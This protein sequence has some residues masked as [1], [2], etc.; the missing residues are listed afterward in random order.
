MEQPTIRVVYGLTLETGKR[1]RAG[2]E[3]AAQAAGVEILPICR[4]RKEG[5]QTYLTEQ[6]GKTTYI[7]EEG[8]Q[9]SSPYTEDDIIKLAEIGRPHIIFLLDRKHYGT[10]YIKALYLSGIL[11]AVFTQDATG[12][13][14]ARLLLFGR[15]NEE[16]RAYYGIQ[17]H[18]DAQKELEE[19]NTEYL[20]TCLAYIEDSSIHSEMDSRYRFAATRLGQEE[21]KVLA[22][23]LSPEILRF[24]EGNEVYKH[25]RTGRE[26]KGLISRLTTGGKKRPQEEKIVCKNIGD[27]GSSH[28]EEMKESTPHQSIQ[29]TLLSSWEDEDM[30]VVMDR[31][32][33]CKETN[34]AEESPSI[35]QD[36]LMEFGLYLQALDA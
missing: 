17:I 27:I 23:S 18:R 12:E 32:R 28:R 1:L 4:Y 15:T 6:Q 19:V 36:S 26:R 8:L 20:D 33:N 11:N 14:L 34:H 2:T 31:F 5:V 25:Y 21:N 13:E 35:K 22:N 30:L 10:R 16:A 24:L 3:Q 9:A 7:L 29:E